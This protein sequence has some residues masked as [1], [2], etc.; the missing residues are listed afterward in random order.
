M[1]APRNWIAALI[2]SLAFGLSV[3][4]V[5]HAGGPVRSGAVA[6]GP[7]DTGPSAS[8]EFAAD[9]LVWLATGCDPHLAGLSPALQTSIVNVAGLAGR[10][11]VRR[12]V[13]GPGTVNGT[14]AGLVIGGFRIQFWSSRCTEVQPE[15]PI[16]DSYE[17]YFPQYIRNES[18]FRI[19]ARAAWMTATADDN[20]FIKWEMY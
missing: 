14:S 15:R 5:A 2:V 10:R 1:T 6:G 3:V 13:V 16:F 9:C 20:I 7:I 17:T 8:C 12:F 18:R 11:T 19:P 4:P